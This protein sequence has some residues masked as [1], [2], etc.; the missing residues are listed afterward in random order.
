VVD[1]RQAQSQIVTC[2]GAFR[3]GSLRIVRSGIGIN[4][5][6]SVELP[7]IKGIWSL[8]S[9]THDIFDTFLVVSFVTET[10]V[11]A[12]NLEDELEETDIEGFV[13][14]AHS[15]FCQYVIHDQLV[16]VTASS[17]RLV[18]APSRKLLTEW[19]VGA[20][21]PII[22]ATANATQVLLAT[23][24]GNLVYL[25]VLEG[26]LTE[27]KHLAIDFD[28]S[29]LDINP[30][31][32]NPVRSEWAVV[33]LWRDNSINV[34]SLPDLHLI[35]RLQFEENVPP[36]SALLC[37]LEG[38]SYLLCGLG[39]GHLFRFILNMSSGELSDRRKIQLGT[40]PINLRTFRAKNSTHVF[41]ASDRPTV[42][43]SSNRKLLYRN[44]NHDEVNHMC[45]F[46]SEAFPGSLAIAN[47]EMLT[48]GCNMPH[49]PKP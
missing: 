46:S 15:L 35:T 33:G 16:Q 40:K 38:I 31:A 4:K 13:S 47:E 34:Y 1:D 11:L 49:S 36:R 28:V 25:E 23:G 20:G 12:M 18:S 14:N 45:S 8:R 30:I 9:S 6:A 10:R 19:R 48:I 3:D 32:D 21:F 5:Q 39:D 17:V 26:S 42:I 43:Y 44:V 37:T 27:V 7:G 24:T 29:C 41:A 22:V 2:S